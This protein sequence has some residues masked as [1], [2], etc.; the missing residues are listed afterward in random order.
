MHALA[1][2]P[3][4]RA[5]CTWI[6]D[7]VCVRV[8]VCASYVTHV[9]CHVSYVLCS[10]CVNISHIHSQIAFSSRLPANQKTKHLSHNRSGGFGSYSCCYTQRL[11]YCC[12]SITT[13]IVCQMVCYVPCTNTH[14]V[15][16]IRRQ[17]WFRPH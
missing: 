5:F 15:P 3:H 10:P 2:T 12:S 16:H 8:C 7:C 11:C 1:C 6:L 17:V 9:V 4:I 14:V 13:T